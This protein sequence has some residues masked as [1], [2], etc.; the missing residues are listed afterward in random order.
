MLV[1]ALCVALLVV[2]AAASICYPTCTGTGSDR[3]CSFTAKLDVFA[4]STGYYVFDECGTET[5]PTLAIERN[6]PTKFYQDHISNWMHPLGFAYEPDGAHKE[7]NELEPGLS[8]RD[9]GKEGHT[10]SDCV[11]DNTCDAPQYFMPDGDGGS[12]F[13]GADG[14]RVGCLESSGVVTCGVSPDECEGV[15]R[16]VV[17]YDQSATDCGGE[18]FGLDVYEPN[19]F[20]RRQDWRAF[21]TEPADEESGTDEGTLYGLGRMFVQLVIAQ[22]DTNEFFYFCHIHNWMSGRIKVVDVDRAEDED[23]E[24]GVPPA[25]MDTL[26]LDEVDLYPPETQSDF[27]KL[28]GTHGIGEYAEGGKLYHL[29]GE[30][31]FVCEVPGMNFQAKR[32]AMCLN[33]MDCA[34]HHEMKVKAHV[35]QPSVTFMHQ[36]IPHHE[37]AVRMAKA[38]LYIDPDTGSRRHLR[39]L[40]EAFLAHKSPLRGGGRRLDDP[41]DYGA[42]DMEDLAW[43]IIAVQNY[44]IMNMRNTF[45]ENLPD[46]VG[47]DYR[48]GE[49]SDSYVIDENFQCEDTLASEGPTTVVETVVEEKEVEVEVEKEVVKEKEVQKSIREVPTRLM[50]LVAIC[51]LCL[52][53][54]LGIC[55]A[56]CCK[57]G[58]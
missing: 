29:C 14:Y 36:M 22:E 53:A 58:F 23:T 54:F 28:C 40:E 46:E 3:E 18:D 12:N 55:M 39:A 27:D 44:Q 8:H 34:M 4:S 17:V 9:D 13:V 5:S 24:N 48:G 10:P 41:S 37:N 11:D 20:V 30:T 47:E 35:S 43:E 33:A 31:K 32:F 52:G 38:L 50:A 1:R 15:V 57:C 16:G 19:N 25:N 2:E 49:T 56:G 21:G 42:I 7:V 6:V 26:K 51:L 45:L